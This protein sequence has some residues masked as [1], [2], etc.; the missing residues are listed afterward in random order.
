MAQIASAAMDRMITGRDVPLAELGSALVRALEEKHILVYLADSQAASLLRETGWGG[1]LPDPSTSSDMLLVVDSNVGFNKADANVSRSLTYVVDL[2]SEEGPHAQVTLEYHNHSV[3]PVQACVQEARYGGT[4]ADMTDRC[5]WDYVRIYVP[6]GSRLMEGPD[7]KLP[8]GSL[9]A[10]GPQA[11]SSSPI[12][13]AFTD[14][15]HE[16]WAAFFE[17]APGAQRTLVFEYQLPQGV[18]DRD[19]EGVLHY[20]LRVLKQPGTDAV[21]MRLEIALPSGAEQLGATHADL[22]PAQGTVLA[23]ST[24]LR[25]DRGFEVL[26]RSEGVKP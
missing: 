18:I 8:P 9:L 5:Y 10:R 6:S 21:P 11:A 16:V 13:P 25:T 7:L 1:M 14:G 4:Y 12:R 24:D 17:V 3:R 19:A 2:A 23:L 20:R 15:D 22:L 26:F